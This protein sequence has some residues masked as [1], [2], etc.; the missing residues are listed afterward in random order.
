MRPR[1]LLPRARIYQ[2]E[3]IARGR[4]GLRHHRDRRLRR[5]AADGLSASRS[6]H[7]ARR[8]PQLAAFVHSSNSSPG[9][10]PSASAAAFNP[11]WP[12]LNFE[13]ADRGAKTAFIATLDLVVN[14]L[15]M[16][17][18]YALPLLCQILVRGWSPFLASNSGLVPLYLI[19]SAQ[20]GDPPAT[21]RFGHR[22]QRTRGRVRCSST[23][24][25]KSAARR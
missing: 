2:G 17:A 22:T 23:E 15:T 13:V 14:C 19:A 4:R 11:Y 25:S 21:R 18:K 9:R 24:T 6:A 10:T 5:A 8:P 3:G 7:H 20:D 1:R 12:F 16:R